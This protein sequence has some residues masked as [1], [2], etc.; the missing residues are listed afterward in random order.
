MY[1]EVKALQAK[2][3]YENWLDNEGVT[4]ASGILEKTQLSKEYSAKAVF[5]ALFNIVHLKYAFSNHYLSLL[6]IAG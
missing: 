1:A 4:L 2:E 6:L 5:I 3:K